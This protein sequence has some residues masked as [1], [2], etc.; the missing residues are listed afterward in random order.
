MKIVTQPT[1]KKMHMYIEVNCAAHHNLA[2]VHVY[3]QINY[4]LGWNSVKYDQWGTHILLLLLFFNLSSALWREKN[5]GQWVQERK[6]KPTG[7]MWNAKIALFPSKTL[8]WSTFYAGSL[9]KLL[10]RQKCPPF[11]RELMEHSPYASLSWLTVA[12]QRIQHMGGNK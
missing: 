2:L 1:S 4:P 11:L 12:L 3:C 10:L 5:T 8:H 9:S 6:H 7:L